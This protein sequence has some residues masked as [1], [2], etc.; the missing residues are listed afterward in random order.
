MG[1]FLGYLIGNGLLFSLA[2]HAIRLMLLSRA[3]EVAGT[4]TVGV[5]IK[6]TPAFT[7][8]RSYKIKISFL[9]ASGEA[10]SGYPKNFIPRD[11]SFSNGNNVGKTAHIIYDP[12][13]P[14]SFIID[15]MYEK[16][17]SPLFMLIPALAFIGITTYFMLFKR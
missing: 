13:D 2:V 7:N 16:Y 12:R 10:M 5:I 11:I 15:N 9:T 6:R 8:G 14:K 17:V 4:K 3:M 1:Q